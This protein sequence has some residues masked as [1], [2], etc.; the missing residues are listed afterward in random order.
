MLLLARPMSDSIQMN[1]LIMSWRDVSSS[2]SSSGRVT[3]AAA[4]HVLAPSYLHHC[5]DSVG[6]AIQAAAKQ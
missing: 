3:V 2:S 1:R 6:V 4:V 5:P